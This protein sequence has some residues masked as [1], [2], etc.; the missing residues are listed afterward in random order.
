MCWCGGCKNSVGERPQTIKGRLMF[1]RKCR[2]FRK[3]SSV[4]IMKV[5]LLEYIFGVELVT[6]KRKTLYSVLGNFI[7][8]YILIPLTLT[9]NVISLSQLL[10]DETELT[11]NR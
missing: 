11:A 3:Y 2:F 8:V 1:N 7:W 6:N 9:S 10:G 5:Y 4:G